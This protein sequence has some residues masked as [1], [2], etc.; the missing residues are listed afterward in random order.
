MQRLLCRRLPALTAT[1][2]LAAKPAVPACA[3]G[4]TAN[5][6]TSTP[7]AT[8]PHTAL[9]AP[10]AGVS[11]ASPVPTSGSTARVVRAGQGAAAGRSAEQRGA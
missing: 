3:T 9:S 11:A 7:A 5:R 1:A 8:T 10:A 6:A 4:A 2:T